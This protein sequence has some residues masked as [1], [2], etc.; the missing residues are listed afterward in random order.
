MATP[1]PETPVPNYSQYYQDPALT[2]ARTGAEQTATNAAQYSSS[3]SLLPY[4]LKQAVLEKLNYNQDLINQQNKAQANYFAAPAEARSQYQDV[5]NPA[6]REK[7]VAQYQAQKYLPYANLTDIL[8]A[9]LGSV[10]DIIGAGTAAFTSESN[11]AQSS[12]EIAR[13]RY[14][15]LFQQAQ[16]L[17]TAL[18]SQDQATRQE[19]WNRY[20]ALEEARK[21][22]SEFTQRQTEFTKTNELQ[23]KQID[24]AVSWG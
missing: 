3:A 18:T 2:Q 1:L 20:N 12:A 6:D 9:R 16:A 22:Q 21:W 14:S 19:A 15:D 11:A 23:N 7:L 13:Q 4:K 8:S 5:W 24:K 17:T 10:S